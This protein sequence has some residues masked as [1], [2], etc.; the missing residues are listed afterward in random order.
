MY[1]YNCP[2]TQCHI[3]EDWNPCF[4]LPTVWKC[5]TDNWEQGR[6]GLLT[7][8]I[9]VFNMWVWLLKISIVVGCFWFPTVLCAWVW[10]LRT[11]HTAMGWQQHESVVCVGLKTG[12]SLVAGFFWFWTVVCVCVCVT[13]QNRSSSMLLTVQN[14]SSMTSE[15]KNFLLKTNQCC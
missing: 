8:Q 14:L 5:W 15:N 13:T 4:G 2:M 9:N 1:G 7:T 10:Q 12:N 3:P 11:G 6:C